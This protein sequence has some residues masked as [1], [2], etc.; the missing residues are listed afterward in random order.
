MLYGG[1]NIGKTSFV[2]AGLIPELDARGQRS[3]YV[4]SQAD[5]VESVGTAWKPEC[6]QL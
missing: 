5:A 3:I 2:R 6:R 4:R 1:S